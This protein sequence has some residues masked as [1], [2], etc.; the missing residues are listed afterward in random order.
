MVLQVIGNTIAGKYAPPELPSP[1]G[2]NAPRAQGSRN[3]MPGAT[4]DDLIARAFQGPNSPAGSSAR[5]V[6]AARGLS[7]ACSFS[8]LVKTRET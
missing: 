1:Q 6:S 3:L 4:Q 8:I 5:E 2:P 7:L